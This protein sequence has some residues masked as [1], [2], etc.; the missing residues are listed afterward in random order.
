MQLPFL[1]GPDYGRPTEREID[2][3]NNFH[4]GNGSFNRENHPSGGAGDQQKTFR[5]LGRVRSIGTKRIAAGV[6]L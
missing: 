4:F 5:P 3:G 1:R 6:A 2:A